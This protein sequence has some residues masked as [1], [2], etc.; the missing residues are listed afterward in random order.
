MEIISNEEKIL[1]FTQYFPELAEKTTNALCLGNRDAFISVSASDRTLGLVLRALWIIIQQKPS[2]LNKTGV[3]LILKGEGTK[4]A[5]CSLFFSVAD[6]DAVC[7]S[8]RNLYETYMS[9]YCVQRDMYEAVPKTIYKGEL[10]EQ[11]ALKFECNV[12]MEDLGAIMKRA[13]HEAYGIL[14]ILEQ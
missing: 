9:G 13:V 3:E 11:N 5:R 14:A 2:A 6:K 4:K 1:E 8:D 12:S 10:K 7:G